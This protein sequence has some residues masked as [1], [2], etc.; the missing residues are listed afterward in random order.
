MKGSLD[1]ETPWRH[2]GGKHSTGNV[3]SRDKLLTGNVSGLVEEGENFGPEAGQKRPTGRGTAS[4]VCW[5]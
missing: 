5:R 2:R 4:V 3:W 1:L